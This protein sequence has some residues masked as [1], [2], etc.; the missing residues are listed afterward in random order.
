M[1]GALSFIGI[2]GPQARARHH[3]VDDGGWGTVT[4]AHDYT[5]ERAALVRLRD[6]LSIPLTGIGINPEHHAKIFG[7]FERLHTV[8]EY[9]GTGI[10]LALVRKGVERMGGRVGIKSELGKG[11]LFWIELPAGEL[12]SE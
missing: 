7:L 2:G 3:G 1:P 11:S 6:R 5:E 9:P 12:D 4:E 10:G 8:R